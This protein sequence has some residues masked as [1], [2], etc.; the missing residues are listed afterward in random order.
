MDKSDD[1]KIAHAEYNVYIH[2][3]HSQLRRSVR[4]SGSNRHLGQ[5]KNYESFK[6]LFEPTA[7]NAIGCITHALRFNFLRVSLGLPFDVTSYLLFRLQ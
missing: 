6:F 1:L 2:C 5:L 4:G 3:T 7:L